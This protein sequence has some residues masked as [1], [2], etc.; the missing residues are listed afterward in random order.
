MYKTPM[1][2]VLKHHHRQ[3]CTKHQYRLVSRPNA[4]FVGEIIFLII[5]LIITYCMSEL[6]VFIKK[7]KKK[8]FSVFIVFCFLL[9]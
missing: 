8:L 7:K 3:T 9:F 6:G 1:S 5:Q 4:L 2:Y